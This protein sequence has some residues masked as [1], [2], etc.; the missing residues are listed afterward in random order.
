[1]I[2]HLSKREAECLKVRATQL[3]D[4][5]CQLYGRMNHS[6]AFQEQPIAV[7]RTWLLVAHQRRTYRQGRS[8]TA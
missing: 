1:M 2:H 6:K 8:Q 3:Q 7:N 4:P 5:T